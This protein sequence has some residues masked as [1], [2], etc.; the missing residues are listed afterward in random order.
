M[1]SLIQDK[2]KLRVVALLVDANNKIVNAAKANVTGGT[3]SGIAI[4]GNNTNG[5]DSPV[6]IYNLQGQ[7]LDSMQKGVNVVKYASGKTVKV[8][9]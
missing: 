7:R 3:E 4:V 5:S 9:K 2:T 8:N 1:K 6:A